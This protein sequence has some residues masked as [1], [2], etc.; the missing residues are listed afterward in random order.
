MKSVFPLILILISSTHAF[1]TLPLSGGII[2]KQYNANIFLGTPPQP[3]TVQIDTGSG[4]LGVNCKGCPNC[5]NHPN[6]PFDSSQ[7]SSSSDITCVNIT[8]FRLTIFLS[9]KTVD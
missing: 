5:Q 4:K 1:Q 9:V 2:Q 8:S 6:P 7:S 3:F